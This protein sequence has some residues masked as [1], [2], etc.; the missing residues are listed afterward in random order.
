[1]Y[2]MLYLI[3]KIANT[4]TLVNKRVKLEHRLTHFIIS[5]ILKNKNII[6]IKTLRYNLRNNLI[7]FNF[8]TF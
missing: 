2:R 3:Y 8:E 7:T 6:D 4:S 5:V 1:M